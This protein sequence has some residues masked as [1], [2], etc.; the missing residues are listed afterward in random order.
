MFSYSAQSL[1]RFNG[2]LVFGID[3]SP[4][5]GVRGCRYVP[6]IVAQQD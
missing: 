3:H 1:N 5:L 6:I 2:M 4:A